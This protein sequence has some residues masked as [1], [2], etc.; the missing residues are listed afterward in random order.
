MRPSMVEVMLLVQWVSSQTTAW[1][2]YSVRFNLTLQIVF[3]RFGETYIFKLFRFGSVLY[4]HTNIV[5]I[6]TYKYSF[7]IYSSYDMIFSWGYFLLKKCIYNFT[8]RWSLWLWKLIYGWLQNKHCG[9]E[10][11]T[12]QWRQ[13]MWWMLP[14][15]LRR[16]QSA[17]MVS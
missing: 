3:F 8:F 2:F 14:D 10:H 1:Y 15:C 9:I 11:S 16:V 17:T 5:S 12:V 7:N 6:S 13:V 4:L